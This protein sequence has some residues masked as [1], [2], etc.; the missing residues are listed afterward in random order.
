MKFYRVRALFLR[1][2]YLYRRSLPRLMEIFY[3]PFLDLLVWG[4]VSLYLARMGGEGLP[5][6]VAFFL[7]ALILWDILFRS[8]QGISVSFLEDVWSRNLL[9][10]FVSPL[11]PIEYILS[12]MLVSAVKIVLVG[13]VLAGLAWLF[14]S[15]NVFVI[16]ISLIPFILSLVALGWAIGIVTTSLILRFGQQAEVL[17][18]GIAFL[19]QPVSAVFYP[20]SVLPPFL[21]AIAK[22][23][24]S[25]HVFEGMRAVLSDGVFPLERLAGA[26]G[27]NV[28]YLVVS[29]IFFYRVFRTVRRKG[30]LAKI[31]E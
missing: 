7:G 19:F 3:W 12:L 25:A 29:F 13:V 18:W 2:M 10:L 26:F 16:G 28:I 5:N 27:L 14:Y 21:Q 15:F 23:V 1:H 24:P 17:A 9:N 6:F 8:Q 30:L 11:R 20:V 22:C 4:F 31:G